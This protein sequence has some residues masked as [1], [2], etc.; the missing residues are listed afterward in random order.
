[1][2]SASGHNNF[3]FPGHLIVEQRD[4]FLTSEEDGGGEFIQMHS[5]EPKGPP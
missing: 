4:E 2:R 5:V 3:W 1:M